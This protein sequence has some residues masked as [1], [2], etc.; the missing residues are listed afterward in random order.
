MSKKLSH[1]NLRL[2]DFVFLFLSNYSETISNMCLDLLQEPYRD[3]ASRKALDTVWTVIDNYRHAMYAQP[4]VVLS[5]ARHHS[6]LQL[7]IV[8]I[9][10]KPYQMA[11]GS[12]DRG[13]KQNM[14][15]IIVSAA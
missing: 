3:A 12:S 15:S 14:G 11:T 2:S 6:I 4:G 13:T 7:M 9:G 5:I 10:R 1:Q 8:L